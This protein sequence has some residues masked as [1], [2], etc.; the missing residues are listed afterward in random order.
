MA[1][2]VSSGLKEQLEMRYIQLLEQ[3]I[4]DLEAV[5]KNSAAS[6]L[7]GDS[8]T[9]T[10]SQAASKDKDKEQPKLDEKEEKEEK[11]KA[12]IRSV[13]ARYDPV[14]GVRSDSE[15]NDPKGKNDKSK[16]YAFTF[17]KVVAS[18]TEGKDSFCEVDIESNG[19]KTLLE[20]VVGNDYPGQSWEGDLVNIGT[21]FAP[22]V[23]NWK[24]LEDAVKEK[25]G[26][27]ADL[28]ESREDLSSLMEQ[29][30]TSPEMESYFKIRTSHL[31]AGLTTYE[32]MWSLFVPGKKLY[33]KLFLDTPQLLEIFSPPYLYWN[34]KREQQPS[35]I[36]VDCW[37]YDWN[38]KNL[39]KVWY[40]I[41][42][43]QFQG[44]KQVSELV[45]YPLEY[46]KD[47]GGEYKSK[48]ALCDMLIDRGSRW[49]NIVLG[50]KGKQ[51]MYQYK[52]QAL[53]DARNTIRQSEESE[54]RT[55]LSRRQQNYLNEL[56]TRRGE[57]PEQEKRKTVF[58][59][60][61][62]I[63]DAEAFLSYGGGE[64]SLGQ[65]NPNDMQ[66]KAKVDI[67]DCLKAANAKFSRE[68][69]KSENLSDK[70]K[71]ALLLL[72]PRFLGYSTQE[73]FW[74]QFKVDDTGDV[75]PPRESVFQDRLQLQ[76]DYKTMIQALVNNHTGRNKPEGDKKPEVKDAV[77]GKGDGLVILLH[78]PPGVGK[79]LT[80]ET[81]AEA[82]GKPLFIVSVAEI[83]LNASK[84]EK[85]LEQ[86]FNLASTWEAVL[87][88]D[89][90]DVFLESRT[91][92]GD[93][94]RN[95][96]V[97]V[98][99]RVLEYYQGIMILTTNRITSLD[100]AV[101][102]RIHLAI[103]YDNLTQD[104]KK[105]IFRQYIQQL[106]PDAVKGLDDIY[107]WVDEYGSESKLN[108]R[109]IRNIVASSLALARST[110]HE[111]QGDDRMTVSHLKKVT[112]MTREFI[113]QLDSITKQRRG[114]NEVSSRK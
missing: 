105:A 85:N 56:L 55:S 109:Q 39:V 90:A 57:A 83:G 101:Q 1:P 89:E 82:S 93:A 4:A 21:P 28:K 43:D 71:S 72:P 114:D 61:K 19:L 84:A 63:V 8:K 86:M 64:L 50:K 92:H 37:C 45:C 88:V 107:D 5:V 54:D 29:I 80:A 11:R 91:S 73:K 44:T 27:S 68:H 58:I 110:A 108:G 6:N 49:N 24:G 9:Q 30:I 51:Q 12:R 31:D 65:Y 23:H 111:H 62:Y 75:Q 40:Y 70:E 20:S 78:G 13:V 96:L 14:S 103:R 33:A 79:T 81:I 98:L 34:G 95:A 3:R 35:S 112:N 41:V 87:L 38:G 77:A 52:G 16:K 15:V 69:Q 106:K 102:S 59:N 48:E 66:D 2:E 53:A 100:V 99:L 113:E 42:I 7:A 97:S 67:K 25:A 17:R 46:Y 18:T 74:G 60:G 94:N 76:E 32:H 104:Y 10:D 26:D 47:D 36:K 22:L